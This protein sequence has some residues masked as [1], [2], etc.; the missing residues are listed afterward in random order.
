[1]K[2]SSN[3]TFLS[4]QKLRSIMCTCFLLHLTPWA[5]VMSMQLHRWKAACRRLNPDNDAFLGKVSR[6]VPPDRLDQCLLHVLF[7]IPSPQDQDQ[8]Q[9]QD[10]HH[11][12]CAALEHSSPQLFSAARAHWAVRRRNCAGHGQESGWHLLGNSRVI[13][14]HVHS[15]DDEDGCLWCFPA[16]SLQFHLVPRVL[17]PDRRHP[18]PMATH[19][20]IFAGNACP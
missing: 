17:R 18:M 11:R 6:A 10:Q 1:M 8:D 3:A 20:C 2:Q 7:L 13:R 9:D 12:T 16:I 14:L 15:V 4:R 5:D 19:S